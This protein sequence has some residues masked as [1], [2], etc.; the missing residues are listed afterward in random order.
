MNGVFM[1]F[2][3]RILLFVGPLALAWVYS[4]PFVTSTI[5]GVTNVDQL[6]ENVM[7]LNIPIRYRLALIFHS[8]LPKITSY[9]NPF[10][11]ILTNYLL[12]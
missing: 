10:T 8:N 1:F 4:R 2:F 9:F 11:N 6:K 7:A 5:L 12:N 3:T